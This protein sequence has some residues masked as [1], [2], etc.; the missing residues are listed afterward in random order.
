MAS[1][2]P[3]RWSRRTLLTTF[4]AAGLGASLLAACSPPAP[5]IAAPTAAPAPPAAG[6]TTAPRETLQPAPAGSTPAATKQGGSFRFL[7]WTEDPPSLDPY[8]NVSFRSQEFAAFFY[9]RLLMSKKG[10][11]IAAQ[12]YI[13]DGDLAESW[14]P[15][16]DG[17]TYT[18]TLRP[19]TKWHNKPPLN[20]RPLTAGDVAWSFEHFMKVSPQKS[21]FD[22][23]TNV[24]APDG[25]TVVFTL[26]DAYAPFEAAIGSPIFWILPREV[27]EQDGDTS[28]HVVGSGPFIFDR[29]DTGI[30]FTGK[31]N[32]NYHRKGE[33]NVDEVVGLIVPDTAT[34]LAGLRGKELDA[35]PVNQQDLGPLKQSNPEIQFVEWEFLNIPFVYWKLDKPPF[36][37]PRVR[38]AISMGMNRD[39]RIKIIYNDRGNWNNFVPWAL[40]EWWLD[41]RGPD[42]GP[43]AK[44][45]QYDPASAKQ[46]LA[47]AGYPNGF[48]VDLVSTPGYGQLWVQGVE[49]MQQD[50]KAIGV[51]ASIKMQEYTSY[52][53]TYF[54]GKFEGGNTLVYGLETPFTEPHDFL[55]GMYHPKGTRNHAGVDDPKLTAMIEQQARTLDHAD[56]K[57]QIFDIQ[58]YLTEQMYY[59][60]NSTGIQTA[61]LSGAVRDYYPPSDFGR[62][63]E[64]YPKLWLDR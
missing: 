34:Q 55:F 9:S 51:D 28:K 45:F 16:D 50:L 35:I 32:S 1:A 5:P 43:G 26:K 61:G 25:R 57:K 3:R 56:R 12:A 21:A 30:S 44:Y 17:R 13:M 20:G 53:A 11:G 52:I 22:I 2:T 60:A 18:F 41:P 58:R 38:Q 4:T 48:Q 64:V 42:M 46:L 31:K 8:V 49:L 14:K 19:D 63:A 40:S 59:P 39:A 54:A 7:A 36:S 33:P 24:A 47:A 15:S 6:A 29:Y 27:I 62:G 10:P 23:V 37:D